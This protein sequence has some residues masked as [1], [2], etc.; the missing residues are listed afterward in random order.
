MPTPGPRKS[1]N[2]A[3]RRAGTADVTVLGGTGFIGTTLVRRM[4]DAG[5]SVRVLA[6]RATG[7]APMFERPAVQVVSGDVADPDA[8]S[9]AI[10]GA[11]AVIHLAHGGSFTWEDVEPTMVR[12]AV[13]VAEACLRHRVKRLVYAGTI[14]SL[15]LGNRR[16]TIT[17]ETP[18]DP[19]ARERGPYEWGKA[20]SE[21]VLLG[22][23]ARQ[24]LPLCIVRP[25][26]V[27]GPGG[28][29]FHSGFG[30][31]RTDTDCVGWNRGTNPLPLVLAADVATAMML[32]LERDE[33]VGRAYNLVGDVR[34][35]A[36]ECVQELRRELQRP[37]AF[38]PMYP[39]QHQALQ[40]SKWGA[41]LLLR[42]EPRRWP[43][44]RLIK[45]MGCFSPFDCSDVKRDLGWSP[46]ADRDLF[47][48]Q[49][50]R[51]PA[52][53]CGWVT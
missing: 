52:R 23:W 41:K 9:R 14:A 29:P 12:P 6:R 34:L 44:F 43:S 10:Q 35:C 31:W 8:V 15:Y 48:E 1:S 25:G 7:L 30:I 19:R 18:T 22:Y 27:L 45:S 42:G 53:Q 17:G 51:V 32:A 21:G 40:L 39:A 46:L 24:S 26:I 5:L 28:T 20:E 2:A 13:H 4:V 47:I 50:I 33:A 16:A 37:L 11:R 38:H 3:A 36:R 49:A